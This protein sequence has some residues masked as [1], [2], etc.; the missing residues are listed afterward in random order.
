MGESRIPSWSDEEEA[1]DMKTLDG[2]SVVG[3]RWTRTEPRG[4]PFK[5]GLAVLPFGLFVLLCSLGVIPSDGPMAVGNRIAGIVV[6]LFFTA[7]G[8]I[9]V[10]G[11]GGMEI[12]RGTG[13]FRQWFSLL[14]WRNSWERDLSE[15]TGVTLTR[16]PVKTHGRH[17]VR[18]Q[19]FEHCVYLTGDGVKREE[20]TPG[21]GDYGECRELAEELARFLQYPLIDKSSGE[22]VVQSPEE[23]A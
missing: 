17:G 22:V 18:A 23:L 8:G 6:G 3:D 16:R 20:I 13:C 15:F 2:V 10:L 21:L 9:P 4:L 19:T 11:R 1:P 12:D 5:I 7:L 14:F